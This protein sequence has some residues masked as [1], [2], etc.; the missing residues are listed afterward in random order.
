VSDAALEECGGVKA[1]TARAL[2]TQRTRNSISSSGLA[3]AICGASADA[4]TLADEIVKLFPSDTFVNS[5]WV[6]TI[7]ALNEI[8]RGNPAQ[9]LRTLERARRYE[10]GNVGRWAKYAR[11]IAYLQL[12]AGTE[13]SAE[14]GNLVEQKTGMLGNTAA[15]PVGYLYPLGLLGLARAS[16][17]SGDIAASRKAYQDLF[18]WWKDADADFKLLRQAK[19][20]YNRLK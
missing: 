6:P 15:I 4:E 20:E 12:R 1:A 18:A 8:H 17:L 10:S 7:R 11:G 3:L 2:N 14:F 13:A 5:L 9:A 19:D 16:A